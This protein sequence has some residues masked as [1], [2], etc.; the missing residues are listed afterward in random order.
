ML[1]VYDCVYDHD[2]KCKNCDNKYLFAASSSITDCFVSLKQTRS[3]WNRKTCTFNSSK[4]VVKYMNKFKFKSYEPHVV[5]ESKTNH[6]TPVWFMNKLFFR[7]VSFIE[8]KT[9]H[10]T[11]VVWFMNKW[12]FWVAP[13]SKSN[14]W[15]MCQC[16]LRRHPVP[17]CFGRPE[18]KSW[19]VDLSWSHPLSCLHTVLLQ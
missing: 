6:V 4:N 10:A 7:P 15:S 14:I 5:S 11:S 18:F 16:A 2:K 1:C 9:P 17:L 8:S 12:L 19:L 13:C 3:S